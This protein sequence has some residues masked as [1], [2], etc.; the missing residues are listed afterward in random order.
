MSGGVT[1]NDGI[2]HAVLPD[3]PFGGI[4]NS[5]SGAY[6]G[7]AGFDTFTHKRTVSNVTQEKGIAEDFLNGTLMS[8]EFQQG[9]N[10]SIKD[11]IQRFKS[12]LG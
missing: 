8:G 10:E 1:R 7:K 2:V 3:A 12:Q 9:V 6:H 11:T 5:G 4:G